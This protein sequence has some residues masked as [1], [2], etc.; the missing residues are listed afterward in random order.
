MKQILF[1][2]LLFL[3]ISCS[4]T[5]ENGAFGE[6]FEKSNPTELKTALKAFNEG[7]DTTYE[8]EGKI[9]NVCSH[10]GCWMTF[11]NDSSEFYINTNE[12]F[13][14]PKKSKGKKAIA[15]GVFVKDE[16]GEI[17]FEPSGVII[18]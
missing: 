13:I 15:K 6:A 18:E 8:I 14:L 7:K 17:S 10:S 1:S 2:I 5:P 4:Q 9:E 16:E 3:A 12:K 11:K